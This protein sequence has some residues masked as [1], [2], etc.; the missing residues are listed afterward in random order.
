VNQSQTQTTDF[1]RR[2]QI[3]N[4]TN[5]TLFAGPG[6]IQWIVRSSNGSTSYKVFLR[7]L[8]GSN[9]VLSTLYESDYNFVESSTTR[10]S[11]LSFNVGSLVNFTP[12]KLV[13]DTVVS[14]APTSGASFY[15]CEFVDGMQRESFVTLPI[16]P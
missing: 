14:T 12:N 9:N 1:L 8:D 3:I 11:Q 7:I 13:L 16:Q 10:R 4:V 6:S 5:S 2:I 15:T